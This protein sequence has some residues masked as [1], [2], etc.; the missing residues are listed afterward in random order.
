M[1]YNFRDNVLFNVLSLNYII[2]STHSFYSTSQ[3]KYDLNGDFSK[4]PSNIL[5]ISI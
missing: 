2:T 3:F 1:Y 4:L 5:K